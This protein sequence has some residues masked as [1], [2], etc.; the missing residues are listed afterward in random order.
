[1]V[2]WHEK[3]I[4]GTDKEKRKHFAFGNGI[5]F[6]SVIYFGHILHVITRNSIGKQFFVAFSGVSASSF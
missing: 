1:M 3:I 6:C 5:H 2:Q 4:I